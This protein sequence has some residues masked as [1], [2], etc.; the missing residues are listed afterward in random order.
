MAEALPET[1]DQWWTSVTPQ[2]V[3]ERMEVA[4]RAAFNAGRDAERR[5]QAKR[6]AEAY[7]AGG[8]DAISADVPG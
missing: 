4:T 8:K 7:A 3:Y 1:F 5:A 6:V 2:I